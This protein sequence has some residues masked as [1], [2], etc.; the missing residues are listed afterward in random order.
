MLAEWMTAWIVNVVVVV[1]AVPTLARGSDPCLLIS[2]TDEASLRRHIACQCGKGTGIKQ[3][4][5][6]FLNFPTHKWWTKFSHISLF[7][8]R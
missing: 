3:T 6:Q 5:H 1:V 2:R 4:P 7:T 8:G